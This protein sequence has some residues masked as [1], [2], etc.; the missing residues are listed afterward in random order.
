MKSK[1]RK[2]SYSSAQGNCVEVAGNGNR[3]FVRD[4]NDHNGATLSLTPDAWRRFA[5]QVKRERSL[6]SDHRPVL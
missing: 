6:A 5:V 1:W 4:T 2:S 3:V